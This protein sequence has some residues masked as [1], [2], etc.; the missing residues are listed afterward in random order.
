MCLMDEQKMWFLEMEFTLG[1]GTMKILE[2]TAK[3]LL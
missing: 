3:D 2:I 1:E